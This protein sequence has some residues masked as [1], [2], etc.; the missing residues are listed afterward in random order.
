MTLNEFRSKLLLLIE[1]K[2]LSSEEIK[3][4]SSFNNDEELFETTK[5]L[6]NET[7][8][9]YTLNGVQK[10]VLD[11]KEQASSLWKKILNKKNKEN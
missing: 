5:F 2:D 11:Y 4:I 1:D 6:S 9:M 3:Y 10:T 7:P 8:Q